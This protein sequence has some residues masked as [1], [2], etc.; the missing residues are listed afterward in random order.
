MS[1]A[2]ETINSISRVMS[3]VRKFADRCDSNIN[4]VYALRLNNT[5]IRTILDEGLLDASI[6]GAHISGKFDDD[7]LNDIAT[8]MKGS[9]LDLNLSDPEI[10]SKIQF[11]IICCPAYE[12]GPFDAL[13][14][15][16]IIDNRLYDIENKFYSMAKFFYMAATVATFSMAVQADVI[17]KSSLNKFIAFLNIN[18]EYLE[19]N[20]KYKTIEA[21]EGQDNEFTIAIKL[22]ELAQQQYCERGENII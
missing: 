5:S 16:T 11:R 17:S 22:T 7:T 20:V 9:S 8:I 21:I 19:K 10:R 6:Y 13:E 2:D 12:K 14:K 18:L 15:L 1:I 3:I 4:A